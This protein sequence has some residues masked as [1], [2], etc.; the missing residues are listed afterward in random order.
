MK[1][2]KKRLDDVKDSCRI[3][4]NGQFYEVNS[5]QLKILYKLGEGNFGEVHL[6]QLENNENVIFATKV[7]LISFN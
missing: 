1:Y 5:K 7:S 4:Y 2:L 6:V 3:E